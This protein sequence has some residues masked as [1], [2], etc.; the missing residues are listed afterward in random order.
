MTIYD[1][2]SHRNE[3][4]WK[5]HEAY[6]NSISD[7]VYRSKYKF[8]S[9]YQALKVCWWWSGTSKY[10]KMNFCPPCSSLVIIDDQCGIYFLLKL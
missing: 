5:F 9:K 1:I 10:G 6:K 4:P 2:T 3:K 8:S 7:Y